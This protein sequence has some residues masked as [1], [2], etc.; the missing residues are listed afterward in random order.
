[1]TDQSPIL[2]CIFTGLLF[3]ASSEPAHAKPP[4]HLTVEVS[5]EG[6]DLSQRADRRALI[7]RSLAKARIACPDESTSERP[8]QVEVVVPG[9]QDDLLALA[10]REYRAER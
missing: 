3:A 5:A 10:Y 8:C 9:N 2:A 4:V 1:M 7:D 6:L